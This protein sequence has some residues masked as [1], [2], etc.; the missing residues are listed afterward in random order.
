MKNSLAILLWLAFP[1]FVQQQPPPPPV[2]FP[3]FEVDQVKVDMAI[4]KGVKYLKS[5]NAGF[6]QPME[7]IGRKM[8]PRELVLWTYVH[9]GVPENDPA[10]V[11]LFDNMIKDKLEATYCVSVQAMILEEV[12]R[13]KYQQRIWQCAKFLVDNQSAQ[14]FWGYGDPTVY[15]EDVPTTAPERKDVSTSAKN[16]RSF[17]V[18]PPPGVKV[19]PP[20]KHRLKVKRD[21]E[22]NPNDNSNTQYATLGLRA[23]YDAGIEL[24]EEVISKLVAWYRKTQKKP[25]GPAIK[26]DMKDAQDRIQKGAS[27][28][29]ESFSAEPAGWCYGDH[30]HKA[31]GSMSAGSLGGLVISR[32]LQDNDWDSKLGSARP[33]KRS[34]KK[35]KDVLE[36]MAWMA[37]NF[38]VTCN[39]GPYEHANFEENSKHFHYYYLYALER[40]GLLYG[41]EW[42]GSHKW[43]PIGAKYLIEQQGANGSWNGDALDTC[44]AI[45]FLKRATRP[46]DVATHSAGSAR[47]R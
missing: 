16:A 43:Y 29:M 26:L 38:S 12:N 2:A 15:A 23:C 37:K 39:P 5:Q 41:T 11:Q 9:A 31:Y 42:M 45:L 7:H 30:D 44:F 6:L 3:P 13:V 32:Y 24:P 36:G 4:E 18:L 8:G 33:V 28:V 14:G 40:A 19:K 34:W 35:D 21:R 27:G 47:N 10:F 22:G 25:E 46:L 1:A 17:D 20:V